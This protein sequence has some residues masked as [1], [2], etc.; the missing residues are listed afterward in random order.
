MENEKKEEGRA[1]FP[2]F[3]DIR[4]KKILIV[5]AG[6]IAARRAEALLGFGPDLTVVAPEIS[7]KILEL[8]KKGCLQ[9]RTRAYKTGDCQGC[10]MVLAASD[11]AKLNAR[12]CREAKAAGAIVNNASDRTQCDFHFPGL[13]RSGSAV[14]GINGGGE[15]HKLAKDLRIRIE[16]SLGS[17]EF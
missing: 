4:G 6:T 17:A 2:L 8:A 16:K 14:I 15:D 13:V 1:Y 7:E 3:V 11:D 9:V 5:G 10:W 12:V